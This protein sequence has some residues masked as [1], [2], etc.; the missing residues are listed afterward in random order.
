MNR[1][2]YCSGKYIQYIL[3]SVAVYRGYVVTEHV[4]NMNRDNITVNNAVN[5][6]HSL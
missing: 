6:F 1:V 4:G 5:T 2:I 3:Q